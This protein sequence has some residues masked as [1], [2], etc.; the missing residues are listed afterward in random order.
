[1]KTLLFLLVVVIALLGPR[2][3]WIPAL[4]A[5]MGLLIIGVSYS[6]ILFLLDNKT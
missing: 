4:I 2:Q 5:L 6:L 3:C 1:M